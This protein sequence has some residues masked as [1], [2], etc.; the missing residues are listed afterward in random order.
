MKLRYG[1]HAD[2]IGGFLADMEGNLIDEYGNIITSLKEIEKYLKKELSPEFIANYEKL[3][4]LLIK[5]IVELQEEEAQ[6]EAAG[7]EMPEK[8]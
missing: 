4:G 8:P 1:P 7:G 3:K 6:P 5:K 2:K